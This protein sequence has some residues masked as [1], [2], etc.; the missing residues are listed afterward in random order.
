MARQ[1]QASV[2]ERAKSAAAQRQ[3]GG[4]AAGDIK[5]LVRQMVPEFEK[6]APRGVE[7]AVLARDAITLLSQTPKLYEVDQT[8]F[9]GALMTC[10]S[11]GLR[12]G[13]GALGQAWILPMKGKAQ[14]LL[15]YQ[16]MIEL[17]HRSGGIGS[18]RAR[19]VHVND[20]FDID[21]GLHE[22][23]KHKP[24]LDGPRG[25]VRGYYAAYNLTNGGNGF[26]YWSKAQMQEH[27]EKFAMARDRNGNI[28]GPWRDHFDAMALK[29]TVRDL[30][31]FMPRSA[32]LD[33][34]QIADG[35]TRVDLTPTAP[36]E[37]VAEHE[38][39]EGVVIDGEA[40]TDEGWSNDE[41][42]Q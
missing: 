27:K 1:G 29:T 28:V 35:S 42:A 6:A 24:P 22:T 33:R 11:L 40:P 23:L 9:L 36:I 39:I 17:A 37:D 30:F 19:V 10:A 5:A 2:A 8:S 25:D 15:G 32:D 13:V 7:A 38:T 14:F 16:G 20:E 3:Q 4:G 12:P 26:T 18:I 41:P 31:R 34:G 21:Y